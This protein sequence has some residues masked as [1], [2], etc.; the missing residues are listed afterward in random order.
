M[1]APSHGFVSKC[2]LVPTCVLSPAF[3]GGCATISRNEQPIDSVSICGAKGLNASDVEAELGTQASPKFL[4][5]F[6]GVV[7]DYERFSAIRLQR[8][9]AR[10]ERYYQSRGY[11]S[12]HSRVGRVVET[13]DRHVSIEIVVD[14]GRPTVARTLAFTGMEALPSATR[15]AVRRAAETAE[16]IGLPFQEQAV[17]TCQAD[18]RKV[19]TERGYA[20][21]TVRCD[22]NVDIIHFVADTTVVITPGDIATFGPIAIQGLDPDHAGFPRISE[23]PLRRAIEIVP[24]EPY[25]TARLDAATS[26]LL[27]LGIFSAVTISPDL[28]H[29]ETRAVPLTVRVEPSKLRALRL[30]AGLEFDEIKSEIQLI[31]GWEDHD[32]LG[33]LRDFSVDFRP[34][35]VLYPTRVNNLVAPENPFPEEKLRL[36]LR[37]PGFLEARTQ[38]FIR[39]EFNVYPLLVSTNPSA[40]DPVV[41]YRGIKGA[42][43]V[44]RT[45]FKRLYVNVSYQ[46]QVESPFSYKAPLDPSLGTLVILYPELIARLDYR[47]NRNHPHAGFYLANNLQVAGGIFR[48]PRDVRVQPEAVV[49]LPVARNLT[50]ATRASIGLLISSNYGGVVQNH[51]NDAVTP[52]NRQA[53]VADIETVLFRGFFSGGPNSNRGYPLRGVAPNGIV[54]FLNPSTASQQVAAGCNPASTGGYAAL[55]SNCSVPI[56]GFTLW[57]FSNE[58]RFDVKGPLWGATFCDMGDVSPHEL[59]QPQAIRLDHLHLS[60]GL[61]ARYDTPLGPI[62]LD[63]GY[64]IQPLQVLGYANETA[65]YHADPSNGLQPTFFGGSSLGSGIPIALA[66]GI[67]EAY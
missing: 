9:L 41:G 21:T 15:A 20:F 52:A 47:D 39:P 60:C 4:G 22:T 25:S 45:F 62:R 3:A 65:A 64:R 49:Y 12:A 11:Y 13:G 5:V 36:Q 46:A 17:E 31:A 57:E 66:I 10:V 44:D 61:G 67:G 24:G 32:F 56:G 28:S 42:V 43:G 58:L 53:R 27:E 51:I 29:P 6:R 26:A 7:Y 48:G 18:V 34:G 40:S 59:G 1:R 14:E 19:L 2:A 30:G 54:P 55:G 16:P 8:D 33:G 63:I 38:G 23:A 50:F 35:V 37:Q